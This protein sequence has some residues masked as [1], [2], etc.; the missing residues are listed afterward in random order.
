MTAPMYFGILR[1]FDSLQS[2]FLCWSFEFV[3]QANA[4]QCETYQL[5]VKLDVQCA[6]P[7][8]LTVLYEILSVALRV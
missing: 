8:D 4:Q 3:A 6:T 1:S 2:T 7:S 5:D